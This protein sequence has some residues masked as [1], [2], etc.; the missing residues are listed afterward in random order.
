MVTRVISPQPPRSRTFAESGVLTLELV[1]AVG[2]LIAVLIPVGFSIIG[3]QKLARQY[4]TR[5]VAMEIVDGEIE[6]LAAGEWRTFGPG[7]HNY[8]VHANAAKNLPPGVFTLSVDAD[9]LRLEWKPT[10]R[11][12]GPT[13]VREIRIGK[14]S[15]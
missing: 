7:V 8:E 4:Y 2:I 15:K 6:V 12:S 11:G 5:A 10:R 3:D 14:D 9:R 1:V 13:V